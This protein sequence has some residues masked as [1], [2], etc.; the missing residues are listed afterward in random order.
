MLNQ[1]PAGVMNNEQLIAHLHANPD[2]RKEIVE[3]LTER[4]AGLVGKVAAYFKHN[5][6][7]HTYEDL[8]NS[9]IIGLIKAIDLFE[10]SL[11]YKFATIC[12]YYVY[13]EVCDQVRD[14]G[15]IVRVP[16]NVY[17]DQSKIRKATEC[18]QFQEECIGLSE[19]ERHLL[20]A[21]KAEL[22]IR[23]VKNAEQAK[24]MTDQASLDPTFMNPVQEDGMSSNPLDVIV[25]KEAKA[26]LIR[27]VRAVLD[28][29]NEDEQQMLHLSYLATES[30]TQAQIADMLG[31]SKARVGSFQ[32]QMKARMG[33]VWHHRT[34]KR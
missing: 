26:E 4:N 28:D 3:E 13:K 12:Q 31:V 10:P 21:K 23:K 8:F 17:D 1:D 9:G 29:L 30:Y 7:S 11:G 2:S 25:E 33:K 32:R 19:Q 5:N 18:T 15:T 14:F 6:H 16:S 20:I 34:F 27:Q 24:R 22:P